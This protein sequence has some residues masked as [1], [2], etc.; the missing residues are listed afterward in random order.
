MSETPIDCSVR[1]WIAHLDTWILVALTG[2]RCRRIHFNRL[3]FIVDIFGGIDTCV[4]LPHRCQVT[5]V[6][7][8]LAGGPISLGLAVWMFVQALIT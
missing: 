5:L 7:R 6:E 8:A 4:T 1:L 3:A 2:L